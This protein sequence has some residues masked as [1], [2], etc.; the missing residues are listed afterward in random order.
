MH[1]DALRTWSSPEA[2]IQDSDSNSDSD[3]VGLEGNARQL[4]YNNRDAIG[5][6][7]LWMAALNI[8]RMRKFLI[9]NFWLLEVKVEV[10][11]NED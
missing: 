6:A 11:Q 8:K 5:E 4:L 10:C 3:S 7:L 2:A 1:L 9:S